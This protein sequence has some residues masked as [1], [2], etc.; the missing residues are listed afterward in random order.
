MFKKNTKL[1]IGLGLESSALVKKA[2]SNAEKFCMDFTSV[3]YPESKDLIK[4]KDNYNLIQEDDF[5][6]CGADIFENLKTPIFKNLIKDKKVII[7]VVSKMGQKEAGF[8]DAF[9]QYAEGKKVILILNKNQIE[10]SLYNHFKRQCRIIDTYY[11]VEYQ[12]KVYDENM[13][14]KPHISILEMQGCLNMSFMKRIEDTVRHCAKGLRRL[15]QD[16]KTKTIEDAKEEAE[17]IIENARKTAAELVTESD[18]LKAVQKEAEKIK[19]EVIAEC[20]KMRE[21]TEEECKK[22]KDRALFGG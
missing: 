5:W 7:L 15:T 19:T 9:I 20:I 14:I 11:T 22:M 6:W 3:Y 16:E 8:T 2:E 13:N 18:V 10:E 4:Y 17:K 1:I 12:D 21:K